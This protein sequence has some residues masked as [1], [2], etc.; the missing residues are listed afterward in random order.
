MLKY[1]AA[2]FAIA[3]SITGA[4]PANRSTTT[5]NVS[6]SVIYSNDKGPCGCSNNEGSWKPCTDDEGSWGCSALGSYAVGGPMRFTILIVKHVNY[7][8][9][10]SFPSGLVFS[11]G[12]L[13]CCVSSVVTRIDNDTLITS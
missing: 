3:L 6:L 10:K 2:L 4:F 13:I 12:V 11:N 7:L 9:D 5:A 8:L 1:A